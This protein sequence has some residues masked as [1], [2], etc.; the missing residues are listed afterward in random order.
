MV[1]DRLGRGS[2]AVSI[3]DNPGWETEVAEPLPHDETPTEPDPPSP[4]KESAGLSDETT[5]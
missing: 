2:R 4:P 5:A 1:R 3:A